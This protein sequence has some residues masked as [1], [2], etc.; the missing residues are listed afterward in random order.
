[1]SNSTFG[2]ISEL[3]IITVIG[4]VINRFAF[5]IGICIKI[6]CEEVIFKHRLWFSKGTT[7]KDICDRAHNSISLNFGYIDEIN[8]NDL[9]ATDDTTYNIL[10]RICWIPFINGIFSLGILVLDVLLLFATIVWFIYKKIKSLKI[11]FK[12]NIPIKNKLISSYFIKCNELYKKIVK[13]I[14]KLKIA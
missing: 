14:M 3:V 2:F 12:I 7:V 4:Y 8:K 11:K 1:M 10:K 13:Y 9:Y 5:W 6:W